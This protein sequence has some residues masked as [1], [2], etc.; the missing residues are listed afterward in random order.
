[1]HVG[2]GFWSLV[3]ARWH[4]RHRFHVCCCNDGQKKQNS[5]LGFHGIVLSPI[6][7]SS[8]CETGV[9]FAHSVKK[10]DERVRNSANSLH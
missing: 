9:C 8:F 5:S 3:V 4:K 1:M 6:L 7:F 2:F 10:E